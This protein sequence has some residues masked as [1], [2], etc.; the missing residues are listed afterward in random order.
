M[1]LGILGEESAGEIEMSV[2]ANAGENIEHLASVGLGVLH[3]IGGDDRQTKFRG[4]I[5]QRAI[6]AFLPA[7]K[8]PLNFDVNIFAAECV[9]QSLRA[10]FAAPGTARV[11]RAGF[12]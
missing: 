6:H 7:Q 8:M 3:A 9:D 5:E 11:P 12:G 10:R 4:E 1:A 2:L